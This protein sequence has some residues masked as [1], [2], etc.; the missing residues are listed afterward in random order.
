MCSSDT[1]GFYVSLV[2][3]IVCRSAD[4]NGVRVLVGLSWMA[5][6]DRCQIKSYDHFH[7]VPTVTCL[8]TSGEASQWHMRIH[9]PITMSTNHVRT[10]QA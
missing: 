10:W 7:H 6:G 2:M 8:H 4:L 1:R 9:Q 5:Y 3:E